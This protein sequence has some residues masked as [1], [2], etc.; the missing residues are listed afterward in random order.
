MLNYTEVF[1]EGAS[2]HRY[3]PALPSRIKVS[4]FKGRREQRTSGFR[5]H[6]TQGPAFG[7]GREAESEDGL[8]TLKVV[9]DHVD[10]RTTQNTPAL[11]AP[12]T[13]SLGVS[14]SH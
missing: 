11:W 1:H 2:S 3:P 13:I 10:I 5:T 14:A 7:Q 8:L 4:P 9:T 6:S 12:S